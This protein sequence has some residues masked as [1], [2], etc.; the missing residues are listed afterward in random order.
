MGTMLFCPNDLCAC[1]TTPPNG[2]LFER[3][4]SVKA[5]SCAP[6]HHMFNEDRDPPSCSATRSDAIV[7][8]VPQDDG[9]LISGEAIVT[10]CPHGATSEAHECGCD[11]NP[12]GMV[13]LFH[14]SCLPVSKKES[15]PTCLPE[16]ILLWPTRILAD[17]CLHEHGLFCYRVSYCKV[18]LALDSERLTT[19]CLLMIA[20]KSIVP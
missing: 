20:G 2:G 1:Y 6:G 8:D 3:E 16:P 11:Y 17:T 15:G 5:Y 19:V 9:G 13:C 4:G 10:D 18:F 14:E 12:V 7:R